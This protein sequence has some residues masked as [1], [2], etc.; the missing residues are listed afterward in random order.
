[1]CSVLWL[2]S[3]LSCGNETIH[4]LLYLY[5]YNMKMWQSNHNS[6]YSTL[7]IFAIFA[8]GPNASK[9]ESRGSNFW[10]SRYVKCVDCKLSVAL[11]QGQSHQDRLDEHSSNECLPQ[12]AEENLK[13]K[14]LPFCRKGCN[15]RHDPEDFCP[16]KLYPF[17]VNE[18]R[19]GY[20]TLSKQESSDFECVNCL[21]DLDCKFHDSKVDVKKPNFLSVAVPHKGKLNVRAYHTINK[22]E[23]IEDEAIG[24]LEDKH[25]GSCKSNSNPVKRSKNVVNA[26]W[27]QILNKFPNSIVKSFLFEVLYFSSNNKSSRQDRK[28]SSYV[29]L[30]CTLVC[31][32]VVV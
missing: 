15:R 13:P 18:P 17:N 14:I 16:L 8:N 26:S 29:L 23:S 25:Q 1:M 12:L 6:W 5:L 20:V 4:A 3:K 19:V 11:S 22:S 10:I 21:P 27:R 24:E 2:L 32:V 7:P 28:R 30:V 31:L 9:Y